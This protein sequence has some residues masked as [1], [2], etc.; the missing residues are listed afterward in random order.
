MAMRTRHDISSGQ[1]NPKVNSSMSA[2]RFIKTFREGNSTCIPKVRSSIHIW[3][4]LPST[5]TAQ[6]LLHRMAKPQAKH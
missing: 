3:K 5:P 6:C 4:P 2:V 1:S